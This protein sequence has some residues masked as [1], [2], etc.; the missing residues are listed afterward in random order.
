[1]DIIILDM[2]TYYD[3]TDFTLKKMTTEAYVRDPRFQVI[4]V[5]VKINDGEAEWASGSH[6]Q[7][8][9]YL[10]SNYDWKNS[11]LLCQN[12]AFDGLIL[13]EHFGVHA[14]RYADTMLMAKAIHGFDSPSSL[15]ALA[16]LYG[17]G[18]KGTE[19]EA[20]SGWRREEFSPEDLDKYGDYCINDV[21]LTHE[22]FMKMLR[23][24]FP[25]KE[26]QLIDL[27]L[28]MFVR[29]R[30][31]LDK[32]LLEAHLVDIRHKKDTLLAESGHMVEDL[33]S[34]LKFAELLKSYGVMP[35]TKISVKTGSE[36]YAFAKSDKEFI[37]LQEHDDFRVQA[38]VAAR[39]GVKSTLE[40]TRT[41]RFLGIA[42][43]GQIPVPLL[44]Y[45]AHTGRWGGS[46]KI[47][48]QNLPSRGENAGKIKNA[49]LAPEGYVVIDSDSSQIEAR[50]L[51]W[52]AEQEDLV[53][54][55]REGKDVYKVM[56]S[57]IYNK[58]EEE[59]NKP[60][61]FMGKTVV[62][63]CGYGMG[64]DKF[65][66]SL[67][68]QGVPLTKREAATIIH[69]Y[70]DTYPKIGELWARAQQVLDY[71]VKGD[72]IYFGRKGVLKVRAKYRSI[73]LPSGLMLPYRGLKTQ[74]T[75]DGKEEYLYKSRYGWNR[76][77]G[78]K[79]VEN[80]CQAI[81]RCIIG[82]QMILIAKRYEV[83]MTVHDAI[84]CIAPEAE[85]E[86]AQ[87]YVE[88]CMRWVPDWAEGL[89]V[90]CES[91]YGRSYGDC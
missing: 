73:E 15:K 74:L 6:K 83:V 4:G 45:A 54:S 37:A 51:A 27:T 19:V 16:E 60:E 58:P 43:R 8:R 34:N 70:R 66:S 55:F 25:V 3:K 59:I 71:M 46:D 23:G 89:P 32:E 9:K 22:I 64:S 44:Y 88:K 28:K 84:A 11:M 90:N 17:V 86:E 39:L 42:E 61:R 52:L 75:P 5:G 29:P 35:P 81:A 85:A 53:T 10:Q 48:F 1:V 63:G 50:V 40:E 36:A 77:Y 26:M 62:L 33:M 7:L 78:G 14:A 31:E 2:E 87:A 18:H 47:N 57:A 13:S 69:K 67:N 80:V 49:I 20:V 38:I 21:E 91:G 82:E 65:R 24:G 41:E 30:L 12:T 76:I 68:M 72:S 79:V 56:A